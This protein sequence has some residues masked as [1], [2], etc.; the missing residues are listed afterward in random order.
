MLSPLFYSF[1]LTI[2]KNLF[3]NIDIVCAASLL[4]F[5]GNRHTFM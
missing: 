2:N 4:N 3:L 5:N 1:Y